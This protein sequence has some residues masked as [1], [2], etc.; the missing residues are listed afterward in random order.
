MVGIFLGPS[1]KEFGWSYVGMI[2]MS[3]PITWVLLLVLTQLLIF[4]STWSFYNTSPH[5]CNTLTWQL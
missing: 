4:G 3:L 2:N 5:I 1:L